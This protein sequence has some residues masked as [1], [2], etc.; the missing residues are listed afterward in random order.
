MT[1]TINTRLST[2][3]N[4]KYK[5][6]NKHAVLISEGSYLNNLKHGVW[7]E[8]YDQTGSLMIE[9][10]Y[11]HGI[12]HGRFSCF[13]PNGKLLS[14]G[15]YID[16]KRE[17]EFL[18]YDDE[19]NRIRVLQFANNNLISDIDEKRTTHEPVGYKAV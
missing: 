2:M 7:R 10:N 11:R 18:V 4:G 6:F 5:E 19:G 17:G 3:K 13:H 9:E 16:G 8:Y 14:E 12:Q 15:N 1:K